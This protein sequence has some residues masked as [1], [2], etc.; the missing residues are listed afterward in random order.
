ML[1]PLFSILIQRPELVVEHL[2]GYGALL[3]QETGQ[4][5]DMLIKRYVAGAVAIVCGLAFVLFAGVAL[6]LG[7]LHNQFHW[8]LLAVPGAALV[9]TLFAAA[10]AKYS[11]AQPQFTELKAQI[12]SDIRALKG[13]D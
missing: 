3:R 12:T 2:S 8:M 10:K 9:V 11:P 13:A 7:A 6:M 1:H 4:A 5:A